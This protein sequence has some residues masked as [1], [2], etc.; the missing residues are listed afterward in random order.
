[1]QFIFRVCPCEP[2]NAVQQPLSSST[3]PY[4]SWS[5]SEPHFF[6]ATTKRPSRNFRVLRLPVLHFYRPFPMYSSSVELCSHILSFTARIRSY[7]PLFPSHS[8]MTSTV[9]A[10]KIFT[11][12]LLCRLLIFSMIPS[13][14][15]IQLVLRI[16]LSSAKC[17]PVQSH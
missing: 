15:R 14:R 1:M 7:C 16:E 3:R 10:V 6:L 4:S 17:P 11:M 9:K 5:S 12:F 2:R 8:N 13:L